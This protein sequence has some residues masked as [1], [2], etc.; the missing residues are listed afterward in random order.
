MSRCLRGAE[1]ADLN[2]KQVALI[3]ANT[4]DLSGTMDRIYEGMVSTRSK[5]TEAQQKEKGLVLTGSTTEKAKKKEDS[6]HKNRDSGLVTNVKDG[7]SL[8]NYMRQR[9]IK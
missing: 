5:F 9:D 3:K 8:E 2:L 6:E 4:N 7:M 1:N